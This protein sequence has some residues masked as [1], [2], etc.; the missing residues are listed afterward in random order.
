[1]FN[2][3]CLPLDKTDTNGETVVNSKE[4]SKLAHSLRGEILR[5]LAPSG[6]HYGGSLSVLDILICL[7][8]QI[9]RFRTSEPSWHYRDR[10]ILSKGHAAV[11]LYAVLRQIG[12]FSCEL[13]SYGKFGAGLEG[14]PSKGL[15]GVDFPTGSLGQGLSVGL[16]MALAM[17]QTESRVWIV[18][19]DGEC[20]EGQVW[21]AAALG[22][23]YQLERLHAI[24]DLNG[25]QEYGWPDNASPLPNATAKWQAFGWEVFEASGHDFEDLFTSMT[26]MTKVTGR[27]SVLLAKTVKGWGVR[28]IASNPHRFHCGS[29]TNAEHESL[30][31]QLDEND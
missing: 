26:M 19:G 28:E 31:R 16:G 9:L 3:L 23:R 6:G 2:Q 30:L 21:E 25:Y 5:A 11:A 24:V 20:Q 10:F 13:T 4:L 29:V 17:R 27:P 7:Y 8:H 18:L 15:P 14:H 1:M 12:F 22:A